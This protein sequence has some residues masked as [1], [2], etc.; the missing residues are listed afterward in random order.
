MG[1]VISRLTDHHNKL[2]VVMIHTAV[3]TLNN[4]PALQSI[5]PVPSLLE[6]MLRCKSPWCDRRVPKRLLYEANLIWYTYLH[7]YR[8][9]TAE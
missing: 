5:F 2:S 3:D 7:K 8:T 9:M 1:T 4:K 6:G